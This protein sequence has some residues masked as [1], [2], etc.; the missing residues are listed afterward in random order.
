MQLTFSITNLGLGRIKGVQAEAVKILA[1]SRSW[2]IIQPV[3]STSDVA[4][5]EGPWMLK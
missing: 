1:T 2:Q 4:A 3:K 5:L